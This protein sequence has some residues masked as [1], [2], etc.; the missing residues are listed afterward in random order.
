MLA[1]AVILSCSGAIYHDKDRTPLEQMSMVVDFQAGTL[2]M[3]NYKMRARTVS[4]TAGT[5]GCAPGCAAW[6]SVNRVSGDVCFQ[7]PRL[8]S[9][10]MNL[11]CKPAKAMF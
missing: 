8:Q 7:E 3:L 5:V 6:V 9:L 10:W 1:A 2:E 11:T 4:D